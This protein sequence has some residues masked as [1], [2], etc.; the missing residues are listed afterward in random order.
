VGFADPAVGVL[1]SILLV[2]AA[3]ANTI[4]PVQALIDYAP[5]PSA[6]LQATVSDAIDHLNR[7]NH[8]DAH[9]DRVCIRLQN[10]EAIDVRLSFPGQTTL[11]QQSSYVEELRVRLSF[12]EVCKPYGVIVHCDMR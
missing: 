2:R 3:L 11:D 7:M 9:L 8:T 10:K 5:E 4:K 1:V 12:E 6:A